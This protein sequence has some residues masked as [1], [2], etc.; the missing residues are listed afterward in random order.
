M[1][2][3]R[4]NGCWSGTIR[5]ELPREDKI[6]NVRR[7]RHRAGVLACYGTVRECSWGLWLSEPERNTRIRQDIE[8]LIGAH[9]VGNPIT[10]ADL[11][12][13][14]PIARNTLR[15]TAGTLAPPG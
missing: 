14:P 13:C 4:D 8:D 11:H 3:T 10:T 9:Q 5:R 7:N 12:D 2:R 6:V 1:F 15:P